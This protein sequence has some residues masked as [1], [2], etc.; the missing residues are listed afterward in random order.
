MRIPALAILTIATVLT[1]APLGPSSGPDVRSGLSDLPSRVRPGGQ[2][3]RL[4]LHLPFSVQR[5]GIGPRR[6]VRHQSIFCERASARSAESP[7]L[8]KLISEQ[9]SST[10]T[11]GGRRLA[12]SSLLRDTP[13]NL[14][15][16][17]G[18]RASLEGNKKFSWI[19]EATFFVNVNGRETPAP[20]TLF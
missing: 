19:R 14:L 5:V 2:L 1:A 15:L 9:P 17:D 3:L 8:L 6:P 10:S 4:P 11:A 18:Q 16:C 13:V 7:R 12:R 20:L